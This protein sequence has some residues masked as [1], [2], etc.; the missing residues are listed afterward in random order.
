MERANDMEKINDIVEVSDVFDG[1]RIITSEQLIEI[2]ISNESGCC[3]R[4]GT[5]CSEDDTEG[6][7]GSELLA[8]KIV[9]A[10]CEKM[11]VSEISEYEGNSMFV[12]LETTNGLLQFCVY[13][14]HDGY[15][16][17]TVKVVSKQLNYED[18]L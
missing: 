12:D 15:Y 1:W 10:A 8:I 13:N 2:S 14:C 17:H 6:F 11:D 18:Y 9:N 5:I 16:G 7:I 3:E 4:W